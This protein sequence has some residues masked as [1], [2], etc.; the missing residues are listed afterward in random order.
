MYLV[1]T[2]FLLSFYWIFDW[3]CTGFVLGLYWVCIGFVLVLHW[4][5]T[6][7]ALSLCWFHA[8]FVLGSFMYWIIASFVLGQ[9]D[10]YWF[11]TGFVPWFLVLGFLLGFVLALCWVFTEFTGFLLGC[12]QDF[13][14]VL[15]VLFWVCIL[16]VV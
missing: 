3:F 10:L 15:L 1:F 6:G 12:Y 2:G 11:C 8:W 16:F 14:R 9:A 7:F 4:V 5:C 13:T